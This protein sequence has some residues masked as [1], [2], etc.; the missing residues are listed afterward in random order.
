MKNRK[1]DIW[2]LVI[3]VL[4]LVLIDSVVFI[5][6]EGFGKNLVVNIVFYI[7]EIFITIWIVTDKGNRKN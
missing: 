1:H 7:V 5:M 3:I 4:V 2:A 6:T